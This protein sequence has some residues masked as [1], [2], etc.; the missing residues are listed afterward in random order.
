M[1]K[2]QAPALV[3]LTIADLHG[4]LEPTYTW[5]PDKIL[6]Q[7]GGI[8]RIA[9][10]VNRIKKLYPEKV[11]LLGSG[12]YFIEDF[13]RGTYFL[14][15]GG[16]AIA[17]FLN[18]L[19]ID[20]STIGNHEFDFGV[21][22][23]DEC[24]QACSFPIIATNIT[25][26][27]LSCHILKKV[28]IDKNGY[29]I[30]ILGAVLPDLVKV[31]VYWF[32]HEA[33]KLEPDLYG[34]IQK[35]VDELKASDRVDFVILLS[36]LGID[37]DRK[38][39]E[40]VTGIDLICGGHTHTTTKQGC[41]IVIQK[42]D[43]TKTVI[44]HPGDKGRT[45]GIIKLWPKENGPLK[46]AC[47]VLEVDASI[48]HDQQ[49]EEK[50][51]LCKSKLPK[52]TVVITTTCPIDTTKPAIRK[53]E[54]GFANFVTDVLRTFFGADIV[55][56]NARGIGGEEIFPPGELTERDLDNLFSFENDVLIRL[57]A[58]GAQIRQALELGVADLTEGNPKNL[59]HVSGLRYTID[60]SQPALI[61][62]VN[63]PGHRIVQVDF[64]GAPLDDERVYDIVIN[65]M[66][67]DEAVY[68]AQFYMFKSTPD[69]HATGLNIKDILMKYAKNHPVISPNKVGR[70]IIKNQ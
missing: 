34:C 28:I 2:N 39:A 16:E 8:S 1:Q 37:E 56:I 32:L 13:N 35:A 50:L 42:P 5:G 54:N 30:G 55:L 53:Q 45:L 70:L 47:D 68:A 25:S 59:I 46:F 41:E 17:S 9:A 43:Q 23:A 48:P 66:M 33:L 19:P 27:T 29:K 3:I 63:Q 44:S 31:K 18:A 67:V 22:A 24:L 21:D 57:K 12:D 7:A 36:H 26:S 10:H 52:T 14:A 69:A 61:P 4:Q 49:F 6:R 38:L 11:L 20:A 51:Q 40:Q 15:C 65:S 62:E 64:G 58:T 60:L